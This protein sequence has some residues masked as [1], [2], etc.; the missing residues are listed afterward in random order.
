MGYPADENSEL[1]HKKQSE[2]S[3]IVNRSLWKI[4]F[5]DVVHMCEGAFPE[6]I[7]ERQQSR[8][9]FLPLAIPMSPDGLTLLKKRENNFLLNL[10]RID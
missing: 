5:Q 3:D 9:C 10:S 7:H 6:Y 4:W 1:E 2:Y 8:E